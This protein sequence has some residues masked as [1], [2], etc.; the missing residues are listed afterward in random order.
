M[1]TTQLDSHQGN[2]RIHPRVIFNPARFPRSG[3][4]GSAL[5]WSLD[6]SQA[7]IHRF[8][9]S[10]D[11]T[12]TK[13]QISPTGYTRSLVVWSAGLPCTLR[14]FFV[15]TGHIDQSQQPVT[16]LR[17]LSPV[18]AL[19]FTQKPP[20]PQARQRHH[21]RRSPGCYGIYYCPCIKSSRKDQPSCAK[22][23]LM[24]EWVCVA[25]QS[26]AHPPIRCDNV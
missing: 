16:S 18:R 26:F 12:H 10:V 24:K 22:R 20:F 25:R 15:S 4:V 3:D 9:C 14:S 1:A 21:A 7:M 23:P 13:N 6:L 11:H 8:M 17:Q 5:P 2:L 19:L